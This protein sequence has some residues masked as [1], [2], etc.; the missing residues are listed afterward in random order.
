VGLAYESPLGKGNPQRWIRRIL[1][2]A[3]LAAGAI[4]GALMLRLGIGWGIALAA[5]VTCA[6]AFGGLLAEGRD[7]P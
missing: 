2:L 6:V 5:L 1:V 4:V 7:R 3:L